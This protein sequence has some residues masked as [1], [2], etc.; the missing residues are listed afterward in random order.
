VLLLLQAERPVLYVGGG[1]LDAAPELRDFVARTGVPVASTLMGLGAFPESH[2]LS[3]GMLGMHGTVVANYAVN[4][5]DLLLALGVRFDDRVTGE[6][7]DSGCRLISP[8]I[9]N[10][11]I[12]KKAG[13]NEPY[14]PTSCRAL[15]VHARS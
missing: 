13:S 9:E 15:T 10:A 8:L 14:P 7:W 5:A 11:P 12:D 1:C 2:A 6:Q 3:L 4:D